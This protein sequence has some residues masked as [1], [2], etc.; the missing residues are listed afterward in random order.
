MR[1]FQVWFISYLINYLYMYEWLI[2]VIEDSTNVYSVQ[3]SR[4]LVHLLT[5][6]YW[7]VCVH[8]TWPV[9]YRL[10]AGPINRGQYTSLELA[11]LTVDSTRPWSWPN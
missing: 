7:Q 4:C 11:Q 5:F 10:E 8:I 3:L 2:L 1:L 9:L 6:V